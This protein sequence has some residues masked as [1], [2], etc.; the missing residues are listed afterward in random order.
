MVGQMM[1]YERIEFVTRMQRFI[2]LGQPQR[3]GWNRQ[4]FGVCIKLGGKAVFE[5]TPKGR[6][7]GGG[8]SPPCTAAE[9]GTNHDPGATAVA[10]VVE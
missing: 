6:K 1:P 8:R 7:R 2:F 10:L 3:I 5:G 9:A 4:I